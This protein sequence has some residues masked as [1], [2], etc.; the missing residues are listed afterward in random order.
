[1]S[2]L[3]HAYTPIGSAHN[4]MQ[5]RDP[6]ILLSG[7]AGTGKSRACLEKMHLMMLLNPGARGI[8]IRKTSVSLKSTAMITFREHVAA[9]AI[10]SGAVSYYTGGGADAEGYRYANGSF[11]GLGGMDKATRI[12]SSEYDVA[13]VQE[14]T[15]LT[16]DDWEAITTRLRHGR[17]SFQQLI[18]DCNPAEPTHWLKTRSDA[19]MT[20]LL[21]SRHE[22]N[23]VLFRDGVAT[24]RGRAYIDQLD[25]LT[26][27]RHARLRKGLWVAAEGQI[28]TE[29][30][31]AIHLVDRFEI[32]QSW[33]R[34]WT[35]DFGFIHPF[36]AQWWA[37]DPDGT[38]Y[39]YR[40][41][42]YT[43]RLVEDHAK[44]MLAS[45][46]DSKGAWTEPKP[47]AILTDHAAEDRAT[48]EKH[49]GIRTRPAH[50]TVSDGLQAVSSRLRKAGNGKPRLLILRD[51]LI[52]R[53]PSLVSSSSPMGLAQEIPAYVWAD[54]KTKEVPV[55][56][57]DDACDAAR[58][59]VAHL[60]LN[61]VGYT[62]RSL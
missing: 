50:K 33:T 45:V 7:P 2:V 49:L 28:W 47:R 31:P 24:S 26:G 6:E 11:L 32:P 41:L 23:P 34:Y 16:V 38:L 35:V 37:E 9:E 25:R 60:D 58:Y 57:Y 51:S 21:E 14:A 17:L 1:M 36:V 46:T 4:L 22:E 53:D 19:G 62:T 18:A 44:Q 61:K 56:E 39:L 15:E 20:R 10:A 55:K 52:E 27:V 12:M 29:Y 42:V 59:V 48:L 3:E 43:Q 30:D 5:Y 8:I 40:E 54:H 13:Y